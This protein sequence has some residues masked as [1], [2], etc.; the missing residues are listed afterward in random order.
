MPRKNKLIDSLQ[1]K[2]PMD[3]IETLLFL[4]VDY[5][6]AIVLFQVIVQRV[7]YETAGKPYGLS[8][9]AVYERLKAIRTKM[10]PAPINND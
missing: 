3:F 1:P 7:P 4:N 8:K 9:H 10:F 6:W 5:I 2:D